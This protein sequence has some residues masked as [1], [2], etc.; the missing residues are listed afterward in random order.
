MDKVIGK[1]KKKMYSVMSFRYGITN[2]VATLIT[3]M[4]S[5]YWAIF[6]TDAVGM[7]AAVMAGILSITSIIDMISVPFIGIIMQKAKF[8]SGK[9]RPWLL[10]G[11]V[12]AAVF[13]WLSF[14]NPGFTGIRQIFWFGGA[15]ILTYLGYNIAFTAFTG[16]LPL[17]A[18][19]PDNR[20]A[21]AAAKNIC[22]S[23]GKFLLS[24]FSLYLISLFGHGNATMGYSRL[25][26]LIGVLVILAH[27]Q[28]F[29]AT[30][31]IDVVVTESKTAVGEVH[32]PAKDDY[33]VSFWEM[34][35]Y[36]ISKP[37]LLYV[38]G[39]ACKCS[40]Y[41]LITA[42]APYYYGYVIGAERMLTVYLS[43]GT[44]LMIAGSFITPYVS[45][46]VKGAKESYILGLAFYAVCLGLAFCVATNVLV[47]TLLMSI[48]YVGYS[49]AHATEITVYSSIVDYTQWK[50]GKDLKPFMMSL[51]NLGMKVGKTVSSFALGLGLVLMKFNKT[52][53]TNSAISGICIMF[54]ALPSLILVVGAVLMIFF[55]LT[56][57]KVR[58][59]QAEIRERKAE[60]Q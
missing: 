31:K 7:E 28:L 57:D 24:L 29:T 44:F 25:A 45:R 5:T 41:F 4:A 51:F 37:F 46:L 15:Y 16:F 58:S 1:K 59:M 40:T 52:N 49:I 18:S 35:K 20:Q 6:L 21:Y 17:M 33:K 10:F 22:N 2:G 50:T 12:T 48:G 34:S 60:Q 47:C 55:P 11:A 14:S 27:W 23:T 13:R 39:S 8:K 19:D 36:A 54:S 38:V 26:L 42:L 9:F 3:T 43:L 30:K 56:D 32:K 53:V